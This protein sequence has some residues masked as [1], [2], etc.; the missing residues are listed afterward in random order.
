MA[1]PKD[2]DEYIDWAAA[3]I[4][5]PLK[6]QKIE[7]LYD[8]NMNN[9]FNGVSQHQFFVGFSR[10][11]KEWQKKYRENTNTELFTDSDEPKLIVKP[12]ASTVEKTYRQNILWN[13]NFPEQ[14][15]TGWYDHQNIY[16]KLNDLVRGSL[17]CRFIDG[18]SFVADSINEY[19]KEHGLQTRQYTQE[20]DDGYYAFH[21]YIKFPVTVID[22]QWNK[23]EINT[24][25]EIQITTQLQEVLR[26]LTHKF[27]ESQ[28]L[29]SSPDKGK[30]KWDFTSSRFKVGYLSHTLHLLES[31]I[32]ESRD[33]V[34]KQEGEE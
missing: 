21:I 28:R 18:P 8:T 13:K 11:S 9:I 4:N 6:E 1:K 17:V 32:L 12:F 27:Y 7:S 22:L 31:V 3:N 23:T 16:S 25:V 30:W 14:P 29:I 26:S 34:M 5:S 19:A 33:R 24:E 10:K 20:R 15:K 2:M